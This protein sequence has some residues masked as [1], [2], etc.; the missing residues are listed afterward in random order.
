MYYHPSPLSP[1]SPL[2]SIYPLSPFHLI[3]LPC[4]LPLSP[5]P[6]SGFPI[7][8]SPSSPSYIQPTPPPPFSSLVVIALFDCEPDRR[9]ELGFREGERIVVVR[10]I[11]SDWWVRSILRFPFQRQSPSALSL[12]LSLSLSLCLSLSLSL[13]QGYVE[14]EPA[15]LGVFPV[16]YVQIST[17]HHQPH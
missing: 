15:R 14:G 2:S 17:A 10:K 11:N 5:P 8:L 6:S 12:S 7:S 4:P 3:P 13:Q 9:D 1:L 16:N